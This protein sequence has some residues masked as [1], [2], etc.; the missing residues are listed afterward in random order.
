MEQHVP[1]MENINGGIN[2]CPFIHLRMR[3]YLLGR[4][5]LSIFNENVNACLINS[6]Y[7]KREKNKIIYSVGLFYLWDDKTDSPK[8]SHRLH[9]NIAILITYHLDRWNLSTIYQICVI[10]YF[11]RIFHQSLPTHQS[12]IGFGI[13]MYIDTKRMNETLINIRNSEVN[14]KS[15]HEREIFRHRVFFNHTIHVLLVCR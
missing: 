13:Y 6:N 14:D 7:L 10:N 2:C 5:K 12:N 15:L 3:V 4:L 1:S 8:N 9:L 11:I